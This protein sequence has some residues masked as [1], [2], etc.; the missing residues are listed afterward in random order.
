M[1]AGDGK[2][3]DETLRL[4]H[5]T[6]A[7][8]L[9]VL[10][11]NPSGGAVPLFTTGTSTSSTDAI[12]VAC[13]PAAIFRLLRIEVGVGAAPTTSESLTANLDAGDGATY[14]S[15]LYSENLSVKGTTDLI[16]PF[17]DGY[18]Y[19]A[20]DEVDVAYANTD[21]NDVTVRVVYE[22]I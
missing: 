2:S 14:D 12:A 16:V 10:E 17:G 19:E 9:K 7:G 1:A 21:N 8:A 4:V 3:A 6:T 22:L 20:D 13:A 5:D 15:L 18:E 11:V